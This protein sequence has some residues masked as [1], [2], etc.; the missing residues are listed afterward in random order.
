MD[1]VPKH[2]N[3]NW[4]IIYFSD[5]RTRKSIGYKTGG[6]SVHVTRQSYMRQAICLLDEGIVS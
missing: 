6:F 3:T 1:E 4:T 5:G 2:R